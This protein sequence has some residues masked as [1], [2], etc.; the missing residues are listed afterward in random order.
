M[1]TGGYSLKS[2]VIHIP[3]YYVLMTDAGCCCRSHLAL[4][5]LVCCLCQ[6]RSVGLI[7]SGQGCVFP[8]PEPKSFR[9]KSLFQLLPF[10]SPCRL[11]FQEKKSAVLGGDKKCHP[12]VVLSKSVR[13]VQAFGR[14]FSMIFSISLHYYLTPDTRYRVCL[15]YTSPSP[16]D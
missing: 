11:L 7:C 5:L 8:R 12:R 15:L 13:F 3:V 2:A 9:E 10:F 14:S 1:I 16:R 6:Y 4:L